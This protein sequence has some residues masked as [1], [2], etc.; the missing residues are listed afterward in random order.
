MLINACI[1]WLSLPFHF[2]ATKNETYISIVLW[3][4]SYLFSLSNS[5][6]FFYF[7]FLR[8]VY[9]FLFPGFGGRLIAVNFLWLRFQCEITARQRQLWLC[10]LI[11][12]PVYYCH[13]SQLA[14]LQHMQQQRATHGA[15]CCNSSVRSPRDN[16]C[17]TFAMILNYA[18]HTH[19]HTQTQL[20]H[21]FHSDFAFSISIAS[22]QLSFLLSASSLCPI[23]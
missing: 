9:C 18:T 21:H 13:M 14:N 12:L 10:P 6:S 19:A 1:N 17:K 7:F 11:H 22:F 15:C 3:L 16:I 20:G 5:S 4:L 8:L 23:H 2:V